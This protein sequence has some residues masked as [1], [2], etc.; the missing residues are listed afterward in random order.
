VSAGF[1]IAAAGCWLAL[2]LHHDR[3]DR[4]LV[5]LATVGRFWQVSRINTAIVAHSDMQV[6]A[7]KRADSLSSTQRRSFHEE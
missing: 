2:G 7:L 3:R 4:K 1:V 6:Q 5:A